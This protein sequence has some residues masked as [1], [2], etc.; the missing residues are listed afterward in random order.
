MWLLTTRARPRLAAECLEGCRRSNMK[1][2]GIVYIDGDEDGLYNGFVTPRN[3]IVHRAEHGGLSQ[4]LR[5]CFETYPN[6]PFYGWLADDMYPATHRFDKILEA[7]AE[8]CCMSQAK[9]DWVY[10]TWPNEAKQGWEPTAGQC[11]G[12]DLVRAV[13]WWALPGTYQAGTD[14]AWARLIAELG[15]M[16]F[17][18][19]VT[20]EHRQWRTGKRTQDALDTD[21]LD[22]N[23][24]AHTQED[25]KVLF[26][27]LRGPD[28]GRTMRRVV[29][30]CPP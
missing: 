25:L 29:K 22:S 14:V 6:E 10:L 4:A 23:G 19:E 26:S 12:G 9:D 11:W 20:V 8:R 27:W 5:W 7:A 28:F 3:W 15:R 18:E 13:G 21:M 24:H 30:N 17:C 2:A 1:S 16:R